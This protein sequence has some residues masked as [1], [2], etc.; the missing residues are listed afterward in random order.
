MT[1]EQYRQLPIIEFHEDEGGVVRVVMLWM[2]Y[3]GQGD[4]V[5]VRIRPLKTGGWSVDDNGEAAFNASLEGRNWWKDGGNETIAIRVL[6]PE[7][8]VL[9][10]VF[11]VASR[12]LVRY[13]NSK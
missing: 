10:A 13:C 12:A 4:N 11:E 7:Q 3:A 1:P 9:R 6:E 5:V 8:D 2:V